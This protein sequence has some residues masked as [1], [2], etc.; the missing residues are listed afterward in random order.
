M[1]NINSFV[2]K[3]MKLFILNTFSVIEGCF[4]N[5]FDY[6]SSS[7]TIPT[8]NKKSPIK[9]INTQKIC[10]VGGF[11]LYLSLIIKI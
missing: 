3:K 5:I 4:L 8:L 1:F 9:Q 10:F 7:P 11:V 6:R 2:F